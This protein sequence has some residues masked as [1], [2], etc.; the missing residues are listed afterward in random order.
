MLFLFQFI[1]ISF[2]SFFV[3][4]NIPI[5]FFFLDSFPFFSLVHRLHH[6]F[7]Y[8]FFLCCYSSFFK[9]H[10][11]NSIEIHR[12]DHL[13]IPLSV[14]YKHIFFGRQRHPKAKIKKKLHFKRFQFFFHLFLLLAVRIGKTIS[15][16]QFFFGQRKMCAQ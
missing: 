4:I 11:L 6:S 16:K 13:R 2:F 9:C 8:Y 3:I 15:S 1:F 14:C 5:D 12:S 10:S 7:I